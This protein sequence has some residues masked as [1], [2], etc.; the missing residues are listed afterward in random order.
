MSQAPTGQSANG[1]VAIL[2]RVGGTI[3]AVIGTLGPASRP[4]APAEGQPTLTE[5]KE[6]RAG[7]PD[8]I[9]AWLDELDAGSVVVVLPSASVVCRT[10][11][12][13][14]AAPEH[15]AQALALQA[16]AHQ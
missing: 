12:L 1:P 16:E 7:R 15:L 4:D 9:A 3:R 14:E 2:H 13:P 11:T 10:C 8:E 5:F 6:F